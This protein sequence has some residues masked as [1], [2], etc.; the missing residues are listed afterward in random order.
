MDSRT[1][2]EK[3]FSDRVANYVRYRPGYPEAIIDLM[4]HE[5]GLSSASVIADIG[6]GTGISAKLFLDAGCTVFGVE[7]NREM[8]EAAEQ[9]LSARPGF[10]SVDGTAQATT[11]P[12]ISVKVAPFEMEQDRN[13]RLSEWLEWIGRRLRPSISY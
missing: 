13:F 12:D 1:A 6:S 3:R 2:P 10:R 9:T 7:P 4:H 5:I 8:R 11:L